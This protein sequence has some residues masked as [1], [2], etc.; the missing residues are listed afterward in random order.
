MRLIFFWRTNAMC[1]RAVFFFGL[2]FVI[3]DFQSVLQS[4]K[5]IYESLGPNIGIDFCL[6]NCF[7][8]AN[9]LRDILLSSCEIWYRFWPLSY[10][11]APANVIKYCY[12]YSNLDMHFYFCFIKR[13][14]GG[15]PFQGTCDLGRLVM[16][17]QR[18][19]IL[20]YN[21]TYLDEP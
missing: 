2:K 3:T 8:I 13:Y 1:K 11:F 21:K 12:V 14:V 18:K 15:N 6:N 16:F 9:F 4:V 10:S 19:E 5:I 20:P 17:L 7:N